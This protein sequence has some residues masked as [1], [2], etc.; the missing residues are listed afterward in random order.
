[1]FDFMRVSVKEVI[2][3]LITS[4]AR[5]L[6]L[7]QAKPYAC[8]AVPTVALICLLAWCYTTVRPNFDSDDANP[9]ILNTAWCLANGGRIYHGIT[10]PPYS[11]AAYTPIY[12][13]VIA[14]PMKFTGINYIPAK[15]VTLL[16]SL[17]I[18]WAFIHLSRMWHRSPR[19]GIWTAFLCL[20]V[21]AI[22]YNVI[23]SHPQMMAVALTLWSLVFFL[24][25]R[26]FP[27][28]I[29][30]P[31]FAVLAF[32]TKQSQIVLPLA[33]VLYL[34]VRNRRW[35]LPY[36]TVTATAGLIPM[37]WLQHATNG[38]FLFDVLRLAELS[39]DPWKIADIFIGWLLPIIFFLAFAVILLWRRFREKAWDPMDYY[40][41]CLIPITIISLGRAG[42]H[43][44]YVVELAFVVFLYLLHTT[45]L[46]DIKGKD[47][48]VVVQVLVLICHSLVYVFTDEGPWGMATIRA[49][50]R[51]YPMIAGISGPILS[52]QGSFALF[53]RGSIYIQLFHFIGLWN[54]GVWDQSPLL[55]DISEHKFPCVITQ[56]PIED[57]EAY[58]SD[59]ERFNFKIITALRRN[60]RL[61]DA[62]YP[63][64]VYIPR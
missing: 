23:R 28:L 14:L 37:I 3:N 61:R 45:G 34:A 33:I 63:Y 1:M 42:S 49:S 16:C 50:E 57:S 64:Y 27:T 32:Y 46:P 39:F 62:I 51:I 8:R 58:K 12:Y 11:F 17:A 18:G 30:S 4:A 59:R 9:E 13:A 26:W 29:I 52:Q 43:S 10:S 19:D 25:N 6:H 47:L 2:L 36:I 56:F 54:V 20:L 21:P 60:Y 22:L 24:K 5:L 44:Q 38:Y 40:L 31:L 7:I 48:L 35:L 55:R 53:S 15:L 41:A